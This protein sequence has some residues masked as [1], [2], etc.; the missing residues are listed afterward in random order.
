[1]KLYLDGMFFRSTGVGRLFDYLLATLLADPSIEALHTAV[2]AA[3]R[4]PFLG[5]FPDPRVKPSFVPY[6]PMTLGDLFLKRRLLRALREEVSLFVF[7]SHNVPLGAPRPFLVSVN[8]VTAFSPY[9]RVP[10]HREW[11]RSAFRWL[12]GRTLRRAARVVTIS[13][14]AERDLLEE[15]PGAR[16]RTEVIHP[17]VADLFFEPPSPSAGASGAELPEDYLLYLGLR[18]HHKNLDGI[19]A[20]FERL[21]PE[22]PRL[23]LVIAGRRYR[24]PDMV[25][26]WKR[27][28]PLAARVLE[29]VGPDDAH[30]VQLLAGARAFVFPSFLEG[31]GLPPL[32]AMAAGVPV[33]CSDL[34]I[35]REVCGE[36][37]RPVD[38]ARPESIASGVREVLTDPA[39]AFSLISAG[40]ERAQRYRKQPSQARYRELV[41]SL[42]LPT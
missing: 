28:S 38:P 1:M 23:H 12:L 15:F 24:D 41:R 9:F 27:R 18:I 4:E 36:A 10:W 37:F 42:A 2:P 25:D 35:F 33:V 13:R 21:A 8:D 30:V 6:G 19:L 17:W 32:E 26:A 22:F 40:R 14:T 5:A 29:I 16:G 20:A 31:F 39:L 3:E 7:P 11:R 34:P